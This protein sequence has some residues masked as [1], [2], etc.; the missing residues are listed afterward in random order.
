MTDP[1]SVLNAEDPPVQPDPA[2][3]AQLRA[4]L[5]SALSLPA[6]SE[7]VVMSG[8]TAA[9]RQLQNPHD[10]AVADSP[11]PAALPYL[12]VA[13]ARSAIDW[14]R[15]AFGAQLID[16]PIEMDDGRIGHAELALAGGVLYLADE[17]IELGLR[18]PATDATSVSLMIAV[19]DTDAALAR[20]R[21][22][23]VRVE[24]EPHEAH[25]ARTATIRD[26]FGH[27][28]MLSGPAREP[29]RA[30][31][32]GY[33]SVW[34]PD[35][36][37]TAA[38]NAQVLGWTYDDTGREVTNIVERI[39]I[40]ASDHS[41]VFCCYA[42]A[43][44]A[45]ART[46]ITAAGG[47][48]GA[49]RQFIVGDGVEAI[50]PAGNPFGVYMPDPGQRRPQLN[51]AGPGELSYVTYQVGD[52]AAFREFYGRLLDWTFEPGRVEDGWQVLG[53]HP[54]G[55]VAGGSQRPATVPMWTVSD[56]DAAVTRVRQAGGTVITEPIRQPYGLM[57]ECSDDQGSRFYLGE[58]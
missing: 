19:A 56:I 9:V 53:S 46:M 49:T 30:G 51:G 27:R 11:R 42:V 32:I 57:A 39:D 33:V 55:G 6:G 4:R 7:G 41:T 23:G 44:L 40:S 35:P 58:F 38:F 43:D 47:R 21:G 45:A 25:G 3:A 13:D 22:R 12:T 17:F 52:S 8:T 26:P 28:W 1:L 18:A 29:I 48:V 31:D 15:D 50:D 37:R 54:M 16:E 14:Y 5:E 10:T 34:T 20:A 24:R 2:F 36:A